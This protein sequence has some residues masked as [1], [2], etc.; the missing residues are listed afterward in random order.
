MGFAFS[1]SDVGCIGGLGF[2]KEVQDA[3]EL[4]EDSEAGPSAE[5]E[6][7]TQDCDWGL[8]FRVWGCELERRQERA[9][10]A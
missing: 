7:D 9:L 3:K 6:E 4:D 5:N 2:T 10:Q 1:V 8:E